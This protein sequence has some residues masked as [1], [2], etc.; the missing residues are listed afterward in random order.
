MSLRRAMLAF[1]VTFVCALAVF[2]L[3]RF[4]WNTVQGAARQQPTADTTHQAPPGTAPQ[5]PHAAPRSF[6]QRTTGIFGI[7]LILSIGIAL[8]PN[9]SAISWRVVA[10][11]VGLQLRFAIFVLL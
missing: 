11:A 7:A 9:R 1:A 3:P 5:A 10:W 4:V 8:S 2:A 6:P